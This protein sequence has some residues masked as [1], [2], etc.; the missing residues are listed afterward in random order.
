MKVVTV[1]I[2]GVERDGV[3]D[4]EIERGSTVRDVLNSL[5]LEGYLL[6]LEGENAALGK[7]EPLYD[8][9]RD[10]QKI[11]AVPEATVGT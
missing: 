11:R 7:D 1:V 5:H 9:V 3:R 6:K 8:L 2:S 4:V 10:G